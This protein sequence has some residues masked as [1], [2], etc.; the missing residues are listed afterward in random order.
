LLFSIIMNLSRV[1]ISNYKCF[2]EAQTFSL[3][4]G[5]NVVVGKNNFGKTALLEA[6]SMTA[7]S[8][9]HHSIGETGEVRGE[10][11]VARATFEYDCTLSD[12][13]AM[14]RGEE[15]FIPIPVSPSPLVSLLRI[16]DHSPSNLLPLFEW[17]RLTPLIFSATYYGKELSNVR[18]SGPHGYGIQ[19]GQW[20]DIEWVLSRRPQFSPIAGNGESTWR[21]LASKLRES[22]R[23][24]RASRLS[25]LDQQLKKVE[26]LDED[27]AN[28]TSVLDGLTQNPKR[29]ERL[30]DLVAEVVPE[31][32]YLSVRRVSDSVGEVMSWAHHVD[33]ERDDVAVSLSRSGTGVG[34][35]LMLLLNEHMNKESGIVLI[36]ELEHSLHPG[37]IRK[38]LDIFA[39]D[40]SDHQFVIGTHSPTVVT[41]NRVSAVI[42]V[43]KRDG[44]SRIQSIERKELVNRRA[45]LTELGTS[46]ADVFGA[47][48]VIWVEGKTEEIC[49]PRIFEKLSPAGD[50]TSVVI[51]GVLSTGDFEGKKD[52]ERVVQIYGKLSGGDGLL[53]P[54]IGFIFDDEG[55]TNQQKD[56]LKKLAYDK[57]LSHDRLYFTSR[58]LFENYLLSPAALAKVL[59]DAGARVT[60][61]SV[62]SWLLA[63]FE[64]PKYRL[65]EKPNEENWQASVHGAKLLNDLFSELSE[66]KVAFDKIQHSVALADW[67]LEHEP[68]AFRDIADSIR[69]VVEKKSMDAKSQ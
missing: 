23:F 30:K 57:E 3:Q 16:Q 66:Q 33:T 4:P 53:P 68:D 21:R 35:V 24:L 37:A 55:R 41:S 49:Y 14:M 8:I 45:V 60:A 61:E 46:I 64:K 1:T 65:G 44:R 52:P 51:K 32:R 7:D 9:P 28:L 27:G 47:E 63:N 10:G 6:M 56:D 42:V 34:H 18:L 19:T 31:I 43:Q 69:S 29:L 58:R 2:N 59:V 13:G 5:I 15:F 12:L 22:S 17:L 38:I 20:L 40:F 39:E 62:N 67:L 11:D 36:D 25:A 50:Y 54:A 48:G 26:R